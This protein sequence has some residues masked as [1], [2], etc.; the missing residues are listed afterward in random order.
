MRA[1]WPARVLLAPDRIVQLNL[2][3]VS[4]SGIGLISEIGMP[5]HSVLPIALAV[6]GLNDPGK[7]TRSPQRSRPPT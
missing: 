5:A 6:P 1:N 2:F 3:D 4:E 7:I